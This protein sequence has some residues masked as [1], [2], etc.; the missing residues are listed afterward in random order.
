[1]EKTKNRTNVQ[2]LLCARHYCV[3]AMCKF[4]FS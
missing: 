2:S 4:L 1:L 3:Y